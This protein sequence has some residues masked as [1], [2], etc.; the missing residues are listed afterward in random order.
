VVWS[1]GASNAIAMPIFPIRPLYQRT[2]TAGPE[3]DMI[4]RDW[5]YA[6]EFDGSSSTARKEGG[7]TRMD[8]GGRPIGL[9]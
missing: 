4:E 2:V 6:G 3:E 8:V 9:Q 7:V 5:K 1:E